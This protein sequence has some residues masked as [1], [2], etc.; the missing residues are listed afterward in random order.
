MTMMELAH[1]AGFSRNSIPRPRIGG[2]VVTGLL[3]LGGYVG[4]LAAWSVLAPLASGAHSSGTVKI[5]NNRKIVQHLEGGIVRDILV[6]DGDEVAAGQVLVRLDDT[7]TRSSWDLLHGQYEALRAL[8][9]RLAAERDGADSITFPEDMLASG[10]E[11]A[12]AEIMR[13]QEAI[14]AA[15]RRTLEVTEGVLG[16][17]MAQLSAQIGGARAEL[18]A[19]ELQRK[20]L[21]EEQAAVKEMVD[22]GL[23]RKPRLLALQRQAAQFEGQIGDLLAQ[24]AKAEQTIGETRLQILGARTQRYDETVGQLRD[25]QT[26]LG[27]VRQ[28]MAAAADILTRTEIRAPVG[29]VVMNSHLF[30]VGGVISPRDPILEIVP[31]HSDLI[32]ETKIK[33]TDIDVVKLGLPAKVNLTAFQQRTTPPLNARVTYVA[34]DNQTDQ[35]SG[36]TYYTVQVT[37]PPSELARVKDVFLT[38]GMPADVTLVQGQRTLFQYLIDPMRTVLRRAFLEK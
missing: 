35:K 10:H 15:R 29:G 7:Q 23:E 13:S 31:T 28:K 11:P 3:V 26:Q 34:A 32:V 19:T 2:L 16:Q 24:I 4:G 20:F 36:Q 12:I 18:N 8:A 17:R 27:D 22:K 25:A 5:D 30:T 38:P 1:R 37:I 33:P 14:F 21:A 6:K 9:V